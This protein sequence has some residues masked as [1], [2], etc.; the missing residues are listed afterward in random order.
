[1]KT[2]TRHVTAIVAWWRSKPTDE[3]GFQISVENL[4]W[5][6]GIIA[7]V[8]IVIAALNGYIQGLIAQI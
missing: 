1:M 6:L 2:L 4:L 5:I 8:A 3:R 7:L